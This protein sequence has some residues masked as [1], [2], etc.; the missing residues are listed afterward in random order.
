[1]VTVFLHMIT[2]DEIP[3]IG[4]VDLHSLP[5]QT[6]ME[7]LVSDF[8]SKTDC[9][10]DWDGSF[11]PFNRWPGVIIDDHSD[12]QEISWVC[13][14]Y[15]YRDDSQ[16]GGTFH[17]RYLPD[18]I[19]EANIRRNDFKGT[20]NTI[21]LPRGMQSLIAS[22]NKLN[23]TLNVSSLPFE[24]KYLDLSDNELSGSLD[25]SALPR[26]FEK[27]LLDNNGLDANPTKGHLSVVGWTS[28]PVLGEAKNLFK[29]LVVFLSWRRPY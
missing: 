12:V 28:T 17:F 18:S 25:L 19:T 20:I 23:G 8:Q 16:F 9:F 4:K 5:T 1:M 22:S 21:E 13:G 2:A 26:M 15:R 24:M 29:P 7:L 27:L 3:G 14:N 6:V 10:N 11:L